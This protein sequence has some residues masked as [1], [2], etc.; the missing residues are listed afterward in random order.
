MPRVDGNGRV[1][2]CEVH[3]GHRPGPGP[4]PQPAGDRPDHRG[5][6]RG[7]LLRDADLRPGAARARGGRQHHRGDRVRGR[8]EPPRLQAD[9]R[10]AGPA[11]ER[12][13][14]GRRAGRGRR[15]GAARLT[16]V[17]KAL[18]YT[19]PWRSG[20]RIE[21]RACPDC[22]GE[23]PRI[24]VQSVVARRSSPASGPSS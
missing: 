3:G 24:P 20:L 7:L 15:R 5:D 10:R 17:R 8:L 13:R 18:S 12:H 6:R 11:G 1:A 23:W 22:R 19:R 2:V 16:S 21:L 9:A 4:D 14:A